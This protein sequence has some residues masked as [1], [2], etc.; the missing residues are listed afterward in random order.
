MISLVKVEHSLQVCAVH[1]ATVGS[2]F[3]SSSSSVSS[4]SPA[5]LKSYSSFLI[6][7]ACE[8]IPP[9]RRN[10]SSGRAVLFVHFSKGG[11]FSR[12]S[13]CITVSNTS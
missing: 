4:T 2:L 1:V 10:K 7:L 8:N 13:L 11:G 5:Y 12:K 3:S 9:D 6:A